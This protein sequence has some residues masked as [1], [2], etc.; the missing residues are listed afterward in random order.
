MERVL[1]D[2]AERIVSKLLMC[3]PLVLIQMLSVSLFILCDSLDILDILELDSSTRCCSNQGTCCIKSNKN[4]KA[5]KG[6]HKEDIPRSML[7]HTLG[8]LHSLPLLAS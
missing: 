1:I 7:S 2:R 8:C 4:K 5:V 6:V 3:S